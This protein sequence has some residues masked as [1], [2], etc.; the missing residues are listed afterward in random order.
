[1]PGFISIE[2]FQSVVIL[3][4]YFIL[5]GRRKHNAMARLDAQ[6]GTGKKDPCLVMTLRVAHVVRDYGM[7]EYSSG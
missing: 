6:E 5:E 2:R 4:V 1:M 7:N 3:K